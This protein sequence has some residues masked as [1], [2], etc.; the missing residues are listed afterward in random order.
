MLIQDVFLAFKDSF[1]MDV[2]I[3][4][5]FLIFISINMLFFAGN[6]INI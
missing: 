5:W 1:V 6:I 2:D 4:N 3:Y